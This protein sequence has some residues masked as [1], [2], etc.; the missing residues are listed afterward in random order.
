ML[1]VF[2]LMSV[3]QEYLLK[4]QINKL[5]AELFLLIGMFVVDLFVIQGILGV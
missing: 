4:P 1:F 2:A 5:I 3:N